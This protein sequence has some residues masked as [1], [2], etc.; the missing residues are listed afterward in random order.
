MNADLLNTLPVIAY[1]ILGTAAIVLLAAWMLKH[2]GS[3]KR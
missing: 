1:L 3:P 2:F